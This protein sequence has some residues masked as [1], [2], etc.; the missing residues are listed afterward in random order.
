MSWVRDL[1][2][3]ARSLKL[4]LIAVALAARD[5]RTP[6]YAKLLVAGCVA[7]ALTPVDLIPDAIPVIGLVDD[8]IFIP[9]AIGFAVRFIPAQVLADC[10]ARSHEIDARLPRMSGLTWVLVTVAWIAAVVLIALWT[11]G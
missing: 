6:W 11:L 3:R 9:I 4:E 2:Q 5:P 10:R 1:K 8:L 7:Y